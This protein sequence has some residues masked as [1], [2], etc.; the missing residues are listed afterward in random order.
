MLRSYYQCGVIVTS[1]AKI[2]LTLKWVRDPFIRKKKKI[3]FIYSYIWIFIIF[4]YSL[5]FVLFRTK[6]FLLSHLVCL[7]DSTRSWELNKFSYLKKK[8]GMNLL[9]VFLYVFA[10]LFLVL[11]SLVPLFWSAPMQR[12]ISDYLVGKKK[13]ALCSESQSVGYAPWWTVKVLQR[14]YIINRNIYYH[15]FI[16]KSNH[17]KKTRWWNYK[18]FIYPVV[19]V[20]HC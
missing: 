5:I 2:L 18:F 7:R 12:H 3:I 4:K 6:G 13:K 8:I 1:Y 10:N 11:V 20:F 14:S 15:I 19:P 9:Y 16:L 17:H